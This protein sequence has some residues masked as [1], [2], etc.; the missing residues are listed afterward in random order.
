[1]TT[2]TA[3]PTTKPDALLRF[4]ITVDGAVTGVTGVALAPLAWALAGPLGLPPAALLGAGL[5]FAVYGAAVLYLGTRPTINRRGAVAVVV[6][7]LVSVLDSLLV[8]VLGGPTTLGAVVLV[9]LAVAVAAIA[10]LQTLGLRR[11]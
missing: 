7:N 8:A 9:A 1:M 2:T 5:F 4:A 3:T 6:I 10:G 11:G